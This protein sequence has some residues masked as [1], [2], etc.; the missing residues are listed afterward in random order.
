MLLPC[1]LIEMC[2]LQLA[3]PIR[4]PLLTRGHQRSDGAPM[5]GWP[6]HP[7]CDGPSGGWTV[8]LRRCACSRW[9]ASCA[10][11]AGLVCGS[12]DR[13]G[14]TALNDG[15]ASSNLRGCLSEAGI[16]PRREGAVRP[17]CNSWADG[18]HCTAPLSAGNLLAL[19]ATRD[20]PFAFVLR[21]AARRCR[22]LLCVRNSAASCRS[23]CLV[24]FAGR[25]LA[26][27]RVPV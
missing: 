5:W 17:G 9:H 27:L 2:R 12:P 10:R 25:A 26:P 20:P 18:L 19:K 24:M 13:S 23:H 16:A 3:L 14:R 6:S 22:T 1:N 21:A 7:S 15:F 8:Q 4:N 11:A